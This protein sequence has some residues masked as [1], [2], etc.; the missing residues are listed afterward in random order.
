MDHVW[1]MRLIP[2]AV[3][4][5]FYFSFYDKRLIDAKLRYRIIGCVAISI[6]FFVKYYGNFY[7]LLT[8]IHTYI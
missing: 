1:A 2:N 4:I 6:N 7:I 3:D 8:Y 5:N